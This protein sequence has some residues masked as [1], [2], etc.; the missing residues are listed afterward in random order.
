MHVIKIKF[1]D[2][3]Y[4]IHSL[5]EDFLD[6][7]QRPHVFEYNS[8]TTVKDL[9]LFLYKQD[10]ENDISSEMEYIGSDRFRVKFKDEYLSLYLNANLEKLINY[11]RV[12]EEIQ[13]IY[14]IG[15][16]GGGEVDHDEAMKMGLKL[17]FN[18]EEK[19]HAGRPH[20]HVYDKQNDNRAS[21]DL[22]TFDVIVGNIVTK[23]K[24]K[25]I[26]YLEVNQNK[27]LNYWNLITNGIKV[28]D[29]DL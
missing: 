23:K 15:I 11:L 17:Y 12:F 27:Y 9:F 18:S 3:E 29:V 14:I 26:K 19:I 10:F 2:Y 20:V 6:Y 1:V 21:V 22:N 5:T 7:L 13:M 4:A 25:L 16:G 28:D 24:K 8:Y